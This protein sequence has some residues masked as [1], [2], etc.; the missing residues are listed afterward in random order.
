[1]QDSSSNKQ[2]QKWLC[3][4]PLVIFLLLYLTNIALPLHLTP[5]YQNYVSRIWIWT[6]ALIALVALYY[7]ARSRVIE[8]KQIVVSLL[9]GLVCFSVLFFDDEF[10][11]GVQTG[12]IVAIVF[13]GGCRLFEWTDYKNRSTGIG[14]A[15]G[16]K[17]FLVGVVISI[18]LALLNVAYFYFT[19]ESVQ[20][21]DFLFS[22]ALALNP[23]ISEEI[24]FRF[25]LL[26]YA[27]RLLRGRVTERFFT[28]FAYIL[29]VV[30]H[31]LIH[32]PD[33]FLESPLGALAMLLLTCVFFGLPMALLMKR[34]NVQAAIGLHW[35][36]DFMRFSA[37]F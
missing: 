4:A 18:P 12:V 2:P 29:M 24:I 21:G 33:L 30:P 1:M 7:I 22:A 9:L 15:S 36:I 28:V 26:A 25:F 31:S 11:I 19:Q 35:F 6:E 10:Q 27:C 5:S 32:L 20:G 23:A 3:L 8:W 34:K 37:G 17:Y 16:M 14:L 13:Y